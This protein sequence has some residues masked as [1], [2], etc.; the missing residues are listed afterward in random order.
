MEAGF[1]FSRP[2]MLIDG[3]QRKLSDMVGYGGEGWGKECGVYFPENVSKFGL[4]VMMPRSSAGFVQEAFF[5]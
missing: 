5:S 3:L 4:I 1:G 2:G